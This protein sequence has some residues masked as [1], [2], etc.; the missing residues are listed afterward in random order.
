MEIF[1]RLMFGHFLADF[2]FQADKVNAWKRSSVW[3]MVLHAGMHPVTY[4]ILTWPYLD[5][6]WVN[7]P[8]LRLQGW[9]CILLLF[10]IHFLADEWRVFTIFRFGTPDNTLYFL[11]DQIIHYLSIFLLVPLGLLGPDAVLVPEKWPILGILLVLATHFTTVLVYFLEKD[12][13]G[14]EFPGGG[15]KYLGIAERLVVSLSFLLAGHWWVLFTAGWVGHRLY[16][17]SR[18]IQDF[19]WLNFALS[20]AM[21]VVC[22][23]GAR[24]VYYS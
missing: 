2:T 22:G 24:L 8:Y 14:R 3:G 23:A 1:W 10:I 17:R 21:A 12:L 5:D 11:W 7:T 4:A 6:R 16:L 19:T 20:G 13:W 18:R 15:E 9:T